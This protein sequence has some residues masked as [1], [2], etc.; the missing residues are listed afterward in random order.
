VPVR[1]RTEPGWLSLLRTVRGSAAR[2][3]RERRQTGWGHEWRWGRP[4]SAVA[5]TPRE[6][7]EEAENRLPAWGGEQE[8]VAS[9]EPVAL[10]TV[11]PREPAAPA[12]NRPSVGDPRWGTT[13]GSAAPQ[14]AV[15]TQRRPCRER[16][17]S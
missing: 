13:A 14:P 4:V 17:S 3:V 5:S 9:R 16:T 11:A 15:V 8:A 1:T 2:E 7:E 6:A 12:A 10:M